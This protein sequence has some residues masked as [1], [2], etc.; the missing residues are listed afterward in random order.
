MCVCAVSRSQLPLTVNH[1][2]LLRPGFFT[3]PRTHQFN[4][5]SKH[6][7]TLH[8]QALHGLLHPG[9]QV[10]EAGAAVD[11]QVDVVVL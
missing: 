3:P 1:S 8:A 9:A 10:A 11:G 6:L 2:G 7:P 4:D 5:N